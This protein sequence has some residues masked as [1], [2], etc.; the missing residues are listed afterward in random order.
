[1]PGEGVQAG[2]ANCVGDDW[3]RTGEPWKEEVPVDQL[4]AQGAGLSGISGIPGA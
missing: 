2:S 3:G 4:G 1:M